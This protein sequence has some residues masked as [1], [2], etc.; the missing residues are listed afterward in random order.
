MS[1]LTKSDLSQIR[2]VVKEEVKTEIAPLKVKIDKIETRLSS[3]EKEMKKIGKDIKVVVNFFDKTYLRLL[4]RIE[5][6]EEHLNLP[7]LS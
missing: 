1:M 3:I 7:P 2:K 4:K 5:R 6:I